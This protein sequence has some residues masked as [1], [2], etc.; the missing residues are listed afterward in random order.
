MATMTTLSELV[1]DLTVL[2]TQGH[3]D[4]P[5]FCRRSSS[6]DVGEANSAR[7]DNHEGECG[8]FDLNGADYVVISFG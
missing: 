6:G 4:K 8:P 2:E 5:V 1:K 3:G 7:I